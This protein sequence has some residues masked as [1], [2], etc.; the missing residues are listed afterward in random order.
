[1]VFPYLNGLIV[2]KWWFCILFFYIGLWIYY[3]FSICGDYICRSIQ[4]LNNWYQSTFL[5]QIREER[6]CSFY[7][8][9]LGKENRAMHFRFI[10]EALRARFGKKKWVFEFLSEK[11]LISRNKSTETESRK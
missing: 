5:G 2:I 1:M 6:F 8:K 11:Y 7:R 4:V 10:S 3:V 9:F